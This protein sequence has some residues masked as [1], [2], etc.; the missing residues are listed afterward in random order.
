VTGRALGVAL[1]SALLLSAAGCHT[2]MYEQ[3]KYRPLE[4]TSFFS[5]GDSSRP[6]P[7]DTVA[8]GQASGD[9]LLTTGKIDG[10]IVDAFPFPVTRAVLERGRNRFDVFCSPCHG[11]TG[12]GR[13]MIVRRGFKQPPSYHTDR[14]RKLPA[15]HVFDVITNGFGAMYDY[16]ARIVPEDRWA[17]VA[18]VRALQLSEDATT[19]DVPPQERVKLENEKEAP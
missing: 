18:Y 10:K 4:E 5:D 2:D 14:M 7:A 13:G 3:P 6:L 1:A 19:A 15:G 8:R 12:D 16:K 17:I 9:E 11:R